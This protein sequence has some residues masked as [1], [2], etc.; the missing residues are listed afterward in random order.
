MAGIDAAR[1]R[2]CIAL[3][4]QFAAE[5]FAAAQA[6][7]AKPLSISIGTGNVTGAQ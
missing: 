5:F 7:A 1:T 6:N 4:R 3:R 2:P